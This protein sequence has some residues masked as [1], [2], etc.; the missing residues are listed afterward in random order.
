MV[1]DNFTQGQNVTL[2]EQQLHSSHVIKAEEFDF[3]YVG[4]KKKEKFLKD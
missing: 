1:P 2:E 4:S 3:E